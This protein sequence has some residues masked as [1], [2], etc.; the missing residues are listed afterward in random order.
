MEAA[1]AKLMDFS[2]P[3]DVALLDQVV[4][5]AFDAS[6]PQRNDANILL[7]RMK[8]S[9]DMWQQAG[10]ILE[11]SQSQH[12]RFIGLQILDGA[13]QTRWKILPQ[14]QRDGIK[15]Y[16]VGKIIQLSQT[17]ESLRQERIFINKI[18]L[19]LVAILKQEWPHNWPSFISDICEA[20]KTNEVLC[21]NNMQ[22]LKL[23]SE[24]FIFSF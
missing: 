24:E 15:T 22:I 3:M 10:T 6:H 8:E 7:M 16:V 5:T 12:T 18:N 2:Q 4:T 14:D 9:P 1:A 19:V 23:L 17:E 20:S 11:Q 21:E 13:I